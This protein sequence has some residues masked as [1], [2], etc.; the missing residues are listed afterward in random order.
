[1]NNSFLYKLGDII[2]LEDIEYKLLK[3]NKNSFIVENNNIINSFRR[4]DYEF[5]WN[6][7]L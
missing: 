5:I 1:M 4:K 2:I 7:K 3:R 6:K